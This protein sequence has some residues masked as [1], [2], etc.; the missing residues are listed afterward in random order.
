MYY[1]STH[2]LLPDKG[3]VASL[4]IAVS[5]LGAEPGSRQDAVERWLGAGGEHDGLAQSEVM[6]A[7]WRRLEDGGEADGDAA[8]VR[9][10][11]GRSRLEQRERVAAALT[12]MRDW[13]PGPGQ[14]MQAMC[15]AGVFLLS[16]LPDKTPARRAWNRRRERYERVLRHHQGGGRLGVIPATL[17]YT[18]VDVDVWTRDGL[19]R[20][21]ALFPPDLITPTS[22]G[23]H[24]W[25]RDDSGRRPRTWRLFGC[26]GDVVSEDAYVALWQGPET[27]HRLSQAEGGVD[28]PADVFRALPRTH[29]PGSRPPADHSP[30]LQRLRGV[31]SGQARKQLADL[32]AGIAKR[33]L[34][35]GETRQGIAEVLEVSERTVRNYLQG[36]A[37][38]V[39]DG[40][41]ALQWLRRLLKDGNPGRMVVARALAKAEMNLWGGMGVC[42][43]VG[44]TVGFEG[45][46]AG[47][48]RSNPSRRAVLLAY[49]ALRVAEGPAKALGS[50]SR[51]LERYL[52]GVERRAGTSRRCFVE[53]QAGEIART[54]LG[55]E[56]EGRSYLESFQYVAGGWRGAVRYR[57]RR[58]FSRH[59][60]VGISR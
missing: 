60:P 48:D 14:V 39:V 3:L 57:W 41:R 54:G 30:E 12:R 16:V 49:Y 11:R 33:L 59:V 43:G 46:G 17:G 15:D 9:G 6:N 21:L 58:R 34:A 5:E 24:L 52:S 55:M 47:M 27:V 23:Y 56:R 42:E 28:Y 40:K 37:A 44:D 29:E 20:L 4:E 19:G 8:P 1:Y 53:S 50:A 38:A 22:K 51:A 31:R 25:Y 2:N 36:D 45:L 26:S 35:E 32:R 10:R 7:I 13:E 18:V